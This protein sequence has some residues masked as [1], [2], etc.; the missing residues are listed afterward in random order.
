MLIPVHVSTVCAGFRDLNRP[1]V[2]G[3]RYDDCI[4]TLTK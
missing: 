2:V 4:N 3:E 1:V